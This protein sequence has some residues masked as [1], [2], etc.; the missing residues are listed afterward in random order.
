MAALP[1]A[2]ALLVQA[3][4]A[5]P[6]V[7]ALCGGRIAT[8]LSGTYPAV[9]VAW[10][11]GPSRPTEGTGRPVL[12]VECWGNGSDA[13]SGEAAS[14]LARAVEGEGDSLSGIYLSGSVVGSYVDGSLIHAPDAGTGRERYIVQVGLVI[15]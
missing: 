5:K 6:D 8:R 14:Q 3:L 11:G 13:A 7:T 12:Q 4:K 15:Q 10:V 9:R 1:D 2:E